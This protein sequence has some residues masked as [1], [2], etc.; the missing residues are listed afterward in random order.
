MASVNNSIRITGTYSGLDTDS[1]VSQLMKVE[2]TKVDKVYKQKQLLNWKKDSYRE[3]TSSLMSFNDEYFNVLKSSTNFRSA[4]SFAK[5]NINSSNDSIVT[6][7]AGAGAESNSHSI[8]VST[9]ASA[10]KIE[11]TAG[12]AD[13]VKGSSAVSN[14]SLSGQQISVELD[15]ATKTLTLDNYTDING[16]KTGLENKLA[17]AFGSG[18]FSVITTDGKVEI[19]NQLNGSKFSISG[20]GLTGLGFASGDNTSNAI[21][22]KSN[23]NAIKNNFTND[24]N[25]TDPN[26]NVTFAIN[27]TTIDVGKTY[28]E[29]TISDVMN[30]VNNSSAGVKMTYNSL[31]DQFKLE[32]TSQGAA[33]TLTYTDSSSGLLK[34]LGIVDGTS[35]QGTDA[36]FTLDGVT[37]MKRSS[38]NFIVD[39]VSYSLKGTSASSVSINVEADIDGVVENIKGF[40]DKYNK[41]VDL[42]NTKLSED[43]DRD[44]QPLTDEEKEAMSDDEVEKWEAKAKT[45]L[46][47]NDSILSKVV[48]DMRTALYEKVDGVSLSL[49]DI[50]ISSTSYLDKGKLSI[51]ETKLKNALTNNYDQVVKLFTKDSQYSYKDAL[52]DSSKRTTRYKE[53]GLAQRLYDVMQDNI[54]TSRNNSGKKGTLLEKAGYAGDATEFNNYLVDQIANKETLIASLEDKMA[55]KEK[56]YY[57]RFAAMENMIGE[58]QS[59][60]SSLSS[61]LGQ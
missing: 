48:S 42:V 60:Q 9:L 8:T 19:A 5:F 37:G 28:G 29:A 10:S 12:I 51:D 17:E 56:W 4:S 18:K 20:I 33:S 43:Y 30:A 16:L 15:G 57:N 31:N 13:A 58:M 23:L 27:G 45:G 11:G 32:S 61:M 25:V 55:D 34:S 52:D 41:L 7:S 38:N 24:L 2:K 40:I 3:V 47:A 46:L 22:L 1:I 53:A 39:G 44:Y 26:A 21:S 54:R 59:Q 36:E 14:F 50:G 6:V 35:T 49:Y